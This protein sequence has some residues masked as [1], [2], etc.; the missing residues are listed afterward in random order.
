[1][2][3]ARGL[4]RP[5]GCAARIGDDEEDVLDLLVPEKVLGRFVGRQRQFPFADR[6]VAR[7]RQPIAAIGSARADDSIDR[8]GGTTDFTLVA[9][10]L[11][12]RRVPFISTGCPLFGAK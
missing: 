4:G 10:F 8:V 5:F 6:K 7:N 11:N 1:M 3:F 12:R 9:L 2:A